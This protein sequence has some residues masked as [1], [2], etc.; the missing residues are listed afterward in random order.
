MTI[1]TLR[2]DVLVWDADAG[3]AGAQDGAGT[4][5]LGQLRWF[6]QTQTLDDQIWADGSDAVFGAGSGTAGTVTLGGPITL[7]NLTFN[8]AGG[9]TYT[10]AGSETL[11][12][13]NSTI[14]AN[15]GV[16][17]EAILGGSTDW[18]KAGAGALTLGGGDSNTNSA[19][20][21]V[22]SGS[23]V[24]SKTSG[25]VALA[26]DVLLNGGDLI[27][28]GINQ[29]AATS[30]VSLTNQAST[31]NGTGVNNGVATTQTLASLSVAGGAFN[32]AFGGNWTITGAATFTGGTPASIYVG[33]SSSQFSAGSLSLVDMNKAGG[34]SLSTPDNSFT[35]YGNNASAQTTVMVGAGGLYLEN[36]NIHMKRGSA[37]GAKGSRLV[38]DG[39]VSTGGSVG[40]LIRIDG[41]DP[42]GEVFIELSSVAGDVTRTF[43]VA[44]GGAD[45]GIEV[46]ITDGAATSAGIT[47][48]GAGILTLSGD[49]AYTGTT[50]L[51]MGAI[52]VAHLNALSNGDITFTG[53]ALQFTATTAFSS[54]GTRIVNSTSAVTLDSNGEIV[55]LSGVID[56]S[57]TGGL[58]KTGAGTLI[59]SEMN[60]YT[61]ATTIS[62]GTL[63]AGS[64]D[65][66]STGDI[67]FGGGTLQYTTASSVTDWASRFKNSASA[68]SLDTNSENV[69]LAGAIDSSN[70]GGLAKTGAGT[71]ELS[72]SNAFTGNTTVD[73]GV[74]LL[75]HQNA[76]SGSTYAGGSGTLSFGSLTAVTFGGL[77][78]ST[79]LALNNESSA[80]VALTVGANNDS[81]AYSGVLSGSGSLIKSGSGVLTLNGSSANTFSGLTSVTGGRLTLSKTA[82]TNAVAGDISI[83]GGADLTFGANNQ[84]ADT[85]SVTMSGAGSVFNGTGPNAGTLPGINETFAVLTISGGTFNS[86]SGSNWNIGTVSFVA[87]ENKLFVGNSSSRQTFGSL[88]LV[89]M[90]GTSSSTVVTNGFTIFGNGDGINNRTMLTIG[91]GGL[92]LDGSR[93]YMG[94]GTSGS[95]LILNGNV[96]TSGTVASSIDQLGSGALLPYVSLS[97]VGG[98]V[99]RAFD[100]GGGGANLTITPGI[101]NGAATTASLIKNGV[102]TLYLNGSEGNTYTGDT[103]VNAGTL[104]L[105]KTAGVASVSGD[106]IVNAGGTLQLSTND[107][108]ADTAGITINGGTISGWNTDETI[109]FLTQN[110]GGLTSGGNVG[111]VTITGALTLAG[112]NTLVIN[113]NSGSSNPSSWN[114]GSAILTGAN[115]LIG[116]TNGDGNPRSSLTIGSG[117]LT[118]IGR[119]I[120]MNVGNAG[121][122][123]NLNG[124]FTGGGTNTINTNSTATIQPL[125]E[126]GSATRTFNILYGTTT[127]SVE[128][129][130]SGGGIVKTGAGLLQLTVGN[131]YS[132]ATTVS[133]GTLSIAGGD[134]RLLSTTGILIDN[135]SVF[136]VGSPNAPNNDGV[137]NRVNTAATLTMGGGT[138]N[139]MTAAAGAHTQDLASLSVTGGA[140]RVN[141]TADTGTTATLTFTGA[142]PYARSAGTINFIQNP[143]DGGSIFFTNAPSGAGNVSGGLLVAAFLNGTDLIA[144]QSGLLTA[145]SGWIAT[146]TD[147]WTN[148]ASMDVTGSNPVAY[149]TETINA[150][151][152]NTAGAFTI[153]LDGTHTIASDTML[154]TPGVGANTSTITGGEL[155]GSAGGE[156]VI[157][158]FNTSGEFEIASVIVDNTSATGLT[159][160]G[161]GLLVLSGSNTYTG[162]TRVND[163]VLRAADGT[164]LPSSSALLLNGGVFES[165]VATFTRAL[166]TAAGEVRLAAGET[167]FSAAGT[168]VTVNIGGGAA[169][170][171]WGG[172]NFDPSAL[173]LNA[174]TATAALNFVNGIDLNGDIR[175]IRVDADVA[176]I[177]GIIGNSVG[178]S[179]AGFVKTG[180]GTLELSQT[181]TFDGGVTAGGG[182]LLLSNINAAGTGDVTVSGGTLAIGHNQALAGTSILTV[183]GGS[184]QTD[185]SARAIGNDVVLAGTTTVNGTNTLTLTGVLSSSG[186]LVKTSNSILELS[187]DNTYTGTTTV[188]GGILRVLSNTA[189]GSTSGA[190]VVTGTSHVELGDGVVVTGETITVAVTQGTSGTGSPTVNR[191]GLQAGV[192]ATAE[193][194]GDVIVGT[195]L[196]R[197]GVQEGGTLTVSGTITD[198]ASS[199]G[200]RLSGELTGTGGLILSGTGN[201]WDGQTEIVRGKV[202]LGVDDALPTTTA[203]DIHFTNTNNTEYAA[204]DMNGFNQT[205]GTLLNEGNTGSNAELTNSSATLSTLTVNQ[206]VASTFGG[207]ITGNLVLIKSGSGVLTLAPVTGANS[208]TGETI[209]NGGTLRLGNASGLISGGLTV[210]GGASAGGTFDLNDLDVS[211]N[212]LNG[213]AGTVSGI[214]ANNST[215][216][217]IRTITVGANDASSSYSGIFADNTGGGALGM[218]A[219]T[220]IGAGT[221]TLSGASTHTGGINVDAGVLLWSGANDLPSA[222]TLAVNAGANFSLADGV[223]R[224]IS[225]GSL[226]LADGALLT[227]D[228]NAGSL[229]QLISTNAATAAGKVTIFLNEISP[230]GLGGTII[231]SANGGLTSGGANYFIANNTN[232]TTAITQSDTA[233][234]I[235]AQTAATPLTDAYWLGG[236]TGAS[237]S[238][239][240]STGAA[241]NWA[242]DAAGTSAGGLVPGGSSV[243]V[244]FSATGATQQDI[245]TTDV[246]MDLASITF[247]G[248]TAVTIS[249][250]NTITL[251]STSGTAATSSGS[252]TTVTAGSAITVTSSAND[253]NT[254]GVDLVLAASQTWNIAG[255]KTLNVGGD[256]SGTAGLT[257]AGAGTLVL[258]GANTYTGGTVIGGTLQIGDGGGTGTLGGGNVVNDGALIINRTGTLAVDNLISGSG[259]LTQFGT[260]ATTL[261]AAHTYTGDTA[262]LGGTLT[263]ASGAS[264]GVAGASA[265][266]LQIGESSTATVIVEAGG[267]L[268][269]GSGSSS[270]L[271]V[272]ARTTLDGVTSG[273]LDMSA[274]TTFTADVGRFQIGGSTL[275]STSGATGTAVGT[276][277]LA[278]NN[279]ITASTGIIVAEMYP[280]VSNTPVNSLLTFGAGTNN[281]TTP[282]VLVGGNR[283]TGTI[284]IASG[285]TLHLDNGAGK[286]NLTI[287]QNNVEST[288]THAVGTVDLTGGVLIASLDQLILGN[289]VNNGGAGSGTATGT[290]TLDATA[291]VVTA[292]SVIIGNQ[293]NSATNTNTTQGTLNFGGGSFTVANDVGIGIFVAGGN[294]KG[295]LNLTGGTF[296]VGGNITST[297]DAKS[298]AIVTLDGA[299]LDMTGGS[300]DANTFNVRSGALKD[301]GEIYNGGGSV[302]V[303]VTKTTTGSLSLIGTNN[304]SGATVVAA[305]AVEVRGTT[306]TGAV[307]VQSGS[308]ILGTGVVQGSTFTLDDGATLRPGDSVADSSHGRLT[309]TP[310]SASGSTSSLQGGIVLSLTGATVTDASYGGNALGSAGYN[311]WVDSITGTGNHD[312]LVFNDPASGSG[313]NLDFLTTTGSLQI[314]GDG[315]T[316]EKG[317]AFNLLDWGSLVTANFAGFT[318]TSGSFLVGNGDE[319]ADLDL[320][321][322]TGLDL[323]W[324]FSRFTTSGVIVVVPEPS[325]ALLFLA[326]V[327]SLALRRRRRCR[328]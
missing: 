51:H 26:G 282:S 137:S 293:V 143:G 214:I 118:M 157:G 203:L 270:S 213:V 164:G 18:V 196:A 24:L 212:T 108:I 317:M 205:I 190:T 206:S 295:T 240:L 186:S 272:G 156:L 144:A 181:N 229:D 271:L 60:V 62:G 259:S 154:V 117:G 305:G 82:G 38:L 2:A 115:I 225:T 286:T 68:I 327:L 287:G 292:N 250:V 136:Q 171:Q 278:Q 260:V 251:H 113:S 99:D 232:Y 35:L 238:M 84:I 10:I 246:D 28:S 170:L 9:G 216:A 30:N 226:N 15:A 34:P 204:L 141:V 167:G 101:T 284:T 264:I 296:T 158:Q 112:G 132:G 269:V 85:A 230:T 135:D 211:V 239:S 98:V 263:I 109:A 130:G 131:S 57:N 210:N 134:G 87:G 183:S 199:F 217:E 194:A 315:F 140:N 197:I 247:N 168:A 105:G 52:Q 1:N 192:N 177:S 182:T 173:L 304:Y 166:G 178:G 119:T 281:V 218:L 5:T 17:I 300:I 290:L 223:A 70:T 306:G 314:V 222:G 298:N 256:V 328:E 219:L 25:A 4:W 12:L 36:S 308:T 133:G 126:I 318:F 323:A 79:G 174:S 307:T 64:A 235:G 273:T 73:G 163:G 81:T 127:I 49:N 228:W 162:V 209:V 88:S 77:A 291:N 86:S 249:G 165:S 125:L 32:A 234:S 268:R 107:Q 42:N 169:T 41:A 63:Q 111:H 43:N 128:V 56:G 303:D 53:G 153:T 37:A 83:S 160:T 96:T 95:E 324:D 172:A 75:S 7:G 255:G 145:Y 71:L 257:Q 277:T 280:A 297:D 29:I 103:I 299:T 21:T 19:K 289:K 224:N 258:A 27:F 69:I 301:V 254:I 55:T 261:T 266:S 14:T 321:D 129:S 80:A 221:L 22:S 147:T 283:S 265:G 244:I 16:A 46:S 313:Y 67:T 138:F 150:L 76:L 78:G 110:D 309:F 201:A 58:T 179:P 195:N 253:A 45:L 320:P 316:A 227:F 285:G 152:F 245:V 146:G 326:G 66:L 319:G 237:G 72:A 207:V 202:F 59:L 8:A 74:L 208:Y 91:A 23:L 312:R 97:G 142:S 275:T 123:L 184:L 215:T 233:V 151:R 188:S 193:W 198:G 54:W 161:A 231:S 47:K 124:D 116:G 93:I 139:L 248:S 242:S 102:G 120:T 33:N 236:L 294:S 189:L 31:L 65:A 100:V 44:G 200:L 3:T 122:I 50:T 90:N 302:A 92:S 114:V 267:E 220:K 155:R 185:G 94:S 13:S 325:R 252:G 106:I 104:R 148:N 322:L 6:N 89:G 40:S 262:V 288:G 39:N 310:A 175:T 191:G 187:G 311:A 20:V 276:A 241:S 274:A 159:K 243:N 48:D 11:T 121:V 279:T 149:T 176:T 61:G 180:G